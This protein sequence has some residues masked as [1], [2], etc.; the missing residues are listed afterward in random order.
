MV[1]LCLK[2]W[3]QQNLVPN[4]SFELLDSC[5]D[6]NSCGGLIEL[7]TPWF[8]PINC[9][10]DLSHGCA[11][12]F[13]GIPNGGVYPYDGIGMATIALFSGQGED[14]REYI[15]IELLEPLLQDSLYEFILR[16]HK[17]GGNEA[18]SVGSVGAYFSVDSTTD[19]TLDHALLELTPQ[20]QRNPDSIMNDPNIWHEW[21]DTLLASGGGNS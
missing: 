9:T 7:A 18:A 12:G 13:C 5:P 8:E 3:A 15:S 1:L 10:S 6:G 4:G 17:S 11:N 19:Y 20:L 14:A 2:S 16:L 21:K